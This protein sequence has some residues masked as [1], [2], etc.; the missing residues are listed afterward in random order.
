MVF[1]EILPRL[2][3]GVVVHIHDIYLP[4]DYPDFMLKRYYNEQYV[5]GALLLANS[6]KYEVLCPNYFIYSDKDLHSTLKP[7][8]ELDVL[9]NVEQHGGSFWIR[10]HS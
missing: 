4:Y 6:H 9:K 7:I 3:P 8:W 1:L 5:L 10:V 2:K